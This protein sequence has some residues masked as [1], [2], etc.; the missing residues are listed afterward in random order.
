[1]EST[2]G[3]AARQQNAPKAR[4]AAWQHDLHAPRLTELPV[5]LPWALKRSP[6]KCQ[7]PRAISL[8]LLSCERALLLGK[9]KHTKRAQGARDE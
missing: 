2:E 4:A 5:Y 1:M 7:G 3:P 8:V 6:A 9:E